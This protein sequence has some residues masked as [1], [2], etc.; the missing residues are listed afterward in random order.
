MQKLLCLAIYLIS[1]FLLNFLTFFNQNLKLIFTTPKGQPIS[2]QTF[3]YSFTLEIITIT[4]Q[5]EN[6]NLKGVKKIKLTSFEDHR[7]SYVET[8]NKNFFVE[9]GINIEF[10]Q[11]DI[12]ITAPTNY[13]V[14]LTTAT[15]FGSSVTI[16]PDQAGT[17]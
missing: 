17:V 14:S 11:D 15:G 16:T 9:N 6:T 13:E 3:K 7:G 5:L 4:N 1:K 2:I 10:L 8:Y 12:S